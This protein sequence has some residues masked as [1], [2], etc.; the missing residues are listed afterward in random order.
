[1]KLV[2]ETRLSVPTMSCGGCARGI[3]LAL[4]ALEGVAR[5]KVNLRNRTLEVS[6][7]LMLLSTDALAEA[8]EETGFPGCE[9]P[10]LDAASAAP[11]SC[12]VD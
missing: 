1:M 8:L 2:K 9:I 10:D 6:H 7:D 11:G 12:Q 3:V 4:E 5:V